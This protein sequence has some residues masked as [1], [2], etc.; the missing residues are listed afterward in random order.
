MSDSA[1]PRAA[2]RQA[3]PFKGFPRQEHWSGCRF[4]HQLKKQLPSWSMVN[5]QFI[6]L[7]ST[8]LRGPGLDSSG[9]PWPPVTL[10]SGST[11]T[12]DGMGMGVHWGLSGKEAGAKASAGRRARRKEEGPQQ[13]CPGEGHS[14]PEVAIFQDYQH[15]FICMSSFL[16]F[17]T[18]FSNSALALEVAGILKNNSTN[19]LAHHSK[20]SP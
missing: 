18:A 3:L 6:P 13:A 19:Y 8:S 14:N 16:L 17:F 20:Q 9:K 12:M 7:S 2:A 1:I 11:A 15:C 10:H 4:H 5:T